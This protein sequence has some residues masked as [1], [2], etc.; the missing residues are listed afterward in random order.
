VFSQF[1]TLSHGDRSLLSA[2]T[3]PH[4]SCGWCI[5][6]KNYLPHPIGKKTGFLI[7][8]IATGMDQTFP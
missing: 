2:K 8:L 1:E 4:L 3:I 6:D 7:I 5:L